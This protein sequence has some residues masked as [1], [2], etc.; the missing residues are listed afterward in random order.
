MS[1]TP[2]PFTKRPAA[3]AP[4][5]QQRAL[6]VLDQM[7]AYYDYEAPVVAEDYSRAA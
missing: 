6:A 4:T 3:N 1:H 7:F 2:V 5:A